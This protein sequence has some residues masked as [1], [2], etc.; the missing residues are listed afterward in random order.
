MARQ[1]W[2]GTIYYNSHINA[3]TIP[4]LRKLSVAI[5]PRWSEGRDS[6]GNHPDLDRWRAR[7]NHLF[8]AWEIMKTAMRWYYG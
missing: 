1:L 6:G 4:S 8:D 2:G 3:Y 5:R 7:R